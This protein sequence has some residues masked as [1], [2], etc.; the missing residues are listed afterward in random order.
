MEHY[1]ST[2]NKYMYEL[3]MWRM[4]ADSYCLVPSDEKYC[5]LY[6][7]RQLLIKD[8]YKNFSKNLD[9]IL[10]QIETRTKMAF[11]DDEILAIHKVYEK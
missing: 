1:P 3:G 10:N 11:T 4:F 8:W 7:Q 5:S 2:Y 9:K 6:E